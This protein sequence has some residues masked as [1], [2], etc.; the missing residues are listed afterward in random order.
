MPIAYKKNI[1]EELKNMAT[2]QIGFAKRNCW[3]K[4]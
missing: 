2:I 3:Q 1:L 4:V